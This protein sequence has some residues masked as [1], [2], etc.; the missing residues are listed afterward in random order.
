MTF[1][2]NGRLL[3]LTA[4]PLLE[5]YCNLT[6]SSLLPLTYSEIF[7]KACSK[8]IIFYIH[9]KILSPRPHRDVFW[10]FLF[11]WIYY[12][13]SSKSTGKETG[14]THLCALNRALIVLSVKITLYHLFRCQK[15]KYL[16]IID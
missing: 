13:H 2:P 14:K 8:V 1:L 6:P 4:N 15:P 12:C 3:I 10:Q 11:W 7:K 16:A 9:R 5:D